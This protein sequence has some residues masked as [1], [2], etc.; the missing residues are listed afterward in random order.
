MTFSTIIER[1]DPMTGVIVKQD[2][3]NIEAADWTMA[4]RQA[5]GFFTPGLKVDGLLNDH[6][7]EAATPEQIK[8]ALK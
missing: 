2:G 6:L 8:K 1:K 7:F 5:K 3:P 4:A